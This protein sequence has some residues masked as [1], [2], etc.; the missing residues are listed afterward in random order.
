VR[1]AWQRLDRVASQQR[2]ADAEPGSPQKLLWRAM[3]VAEKSSSVLSTL[4]F[5][6]F[7]WRGVFRT[8]EDR[9]MN[10]R[11]DYIKPNAIRTVTFEF[12]NRQLVWEGFTDFVLFMAPLLRSSRWLGILR[13]KAASALGIL[14]GG[15]DFPLEAMPSAEDGLSCKICQKS[16][17]MMPHFALPCNHRFCYTCITSKIET[18]AS[19]R[20]P[21]CATVVEDVVRDRY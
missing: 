3:R 14:S 18:E 16:T 10:A 8:L 6:I 2:W 15:R 4:N 13:A 11:L 1:Y 17:L 12:L 19:Y 5:L 21:I 7:I 20:C 9:L